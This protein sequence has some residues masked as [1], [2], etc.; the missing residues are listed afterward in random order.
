MRSKNVRRVARRWS[1]I[2]TAGQSQKDE[3]FHVFKNEGIVFT[4]VLRF[5]TQTTSL[6]TI[7][8][9]FSKRLCD[10]RNVV[11]QKTRLSTKNRKRRRRC[12]TGTPRISRRYGLSLSKR[13]VVRSSGRLLRSR[14]GRR[15]FRPKLNVFNVVCHVG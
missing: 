15:M 5:G 3:F 11:A 6:R 7:D 14:H 13:H 4:S 8:E 1:F 10:G 12:R 9:A 2:I